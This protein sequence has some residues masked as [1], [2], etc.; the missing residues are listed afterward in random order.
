MF[1]FLTQKAAQTHTQHTDE[2]RDLET[3]SA[4]WANLVKIR[5]I[6][7]EGAKTFFNTAHHCTINFSSIHSIQ[8][9]MP[10]PLC[11][12]MLQHWV[13]WRTEECG[14]Q[15]HFLLVPC[16][17]SCPAVWT[18]SMVWAC[19]FVSSCTSTLIICGVFCTSNNVI[20][21]TENS[22]S[23]TRQASI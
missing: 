5:D 23:Y 18:I 1:F 7:L 2:H 4:R 21:T 22:A 20:P 10:Q 11:S 9:W 8:H 3:E 17:S 13:S 15:Q 19:H 14:W 12:Q 16:R 6:D